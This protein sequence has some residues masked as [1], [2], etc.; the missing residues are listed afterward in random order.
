MT[1][2]YKRG[3]TRADG[4]VFNRYKKG[5]ECWTTIDKLAAQRECAALAARRF[6]ADPVTKKRL[7]KEERLRKATPEARKRINDRDKARKL[8]EPLYALKSRLRSLVS[9]ALYRRG[10][11]KKSR[12]AALLGCTWDYF[13]AHIERQ[14]TDGM[15][16]E[17]FPEIHL[18]HIKPMA[19]ASSEDEAVARCH[20]TNFQPLWAADNIRKGSK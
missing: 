15:C 3:D 14:F 8:A 18:D 2:Q 9:T 7:A 13:A 16:W 1:P 10:Y 12:T 5:K 6:R 20:Y 17:R 19:T 4:K 11:S